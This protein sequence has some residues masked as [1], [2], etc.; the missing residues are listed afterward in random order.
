MVLFKFTKAILEGRPIDVYNN[1][2]MKRDFTY[3]DDVVEAFV[4]IMDIVPT[5]DSRWS[6]DD[7]D[8]SSS[9]APFRL[10]NVGHHEPVDL[11]GV[12]GLLEETLGRK[13]DKRRLPIQPGD[14]PVT[15]ADIDGLQQVTGF[16]PQTS[17]REG[18]Q[19][20]VAWYSEFYGNGYHPRS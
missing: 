12:I 9:V 11:M 2:D 18:I 14:V 1:G 20:F 17:I 7:P 13:A 19:K 16:T 4:R 15:Y 6:G 5:T 3:I 10:Y 8:P